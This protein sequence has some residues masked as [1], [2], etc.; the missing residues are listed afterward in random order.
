MKMRIFPAN[1]ALDKEIS[2]LLSQINHLRNGDTAQLISESGAS[3]LKNYGVMLVHLRQMGKS[4]TKNNELARRLWFR[5]IRE[6]MILATLVALPDELKD[7]EL[8][9]WGEMTGTVEL[10]EQMA[11]NILGKR[12]GSG[13]LLFSW[14]NSSS[15]LLSYAAA[16]GI[17]WQFR[18][19]GATGFGNL[20]CC[21]KRLEELSAQPGFI[22]PVGHVLKMAGRFSPANRDLIMN[23]V[24]EWSSSA[25]E[26]TRQV[27]ME[28]V[29]ELEGPPDL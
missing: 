20:S 16:M 21:M 26:P 13:D 23:T 28:T 17:G 9:E 19:L 10:A 15:R 29:F 5:E 4:C 11:L 18:F 24:R 2:A 25:N 1:E 8:N 14:L 3:Y 6:T 12:A 7:E 27:A 22:H